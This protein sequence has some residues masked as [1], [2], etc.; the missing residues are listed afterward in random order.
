MGRLSASE[1]SQ[2]QFS[3]KNALDV[4]PIHREMPCDYSSTQEGKFLQ[5]ALKSRLKKIRGLPARSSPPHER[6]PDLNL[7]SH[8]LTVDNEIAFS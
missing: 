3:I 8:V 2:T 4:S 7:L 5:K 6:S 1:F